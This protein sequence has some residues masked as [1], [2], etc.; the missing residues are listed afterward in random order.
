M[1]QINAKAVASY[2]LLPELGPRIRRLFLSGFGMIAYLMA[3]LYNAVRL[4]PYNH[5]YLSPKNIG[6]YGI[7]HVIG[8]AANN[9]VI[10]KENWDQILIFTA[11]LTGLILLFTQILILIFVFIIQP[12]FAQS[13]FGTP[14]PS[15]GAVTDVAFLLLDR[16]FGVPD[17]FCTVGGA[18]TDVLSGGRW[19]FHVALHEM[20]RFY[21][22]GLLIVAVLIFVYYIVVVVGETATTG[23]PFGERFQN[24]WVPI[25]LVVALFLLVP[26]NYGLNTAQY[27]ALFAAKTGSGFATNGWIMFN[28]T[29]AASM[30]ARAN[31]TGESETLLA[32]PVEPSIESVVRSMALVHG[33]AYAH[34]RGHIAPETNGAYPAQAITSSTIEP[35]FVKNP[36]DWLGG[37]TVPQQVAGSYADGLTFYGNSDITIRFGRDVSGTDAEGR[38][39]GDIEPTCGEIRINITSAS[40]DMSVGGAPMVQQAYYD[41]VMSLWSGSALLRDLGHRVVEKNYKIDD[42]VN[43]GDTPFVCQIGCGHSELPSCYVINSE[44]NVLKCRS[45]NVAFDGSIITQVSVPNQSVINAAIQ[46]AWNLYNLNAIDIEMENELKDR[47]WGG[48]GIWY[49]KI[50]KINGEFIGAVQNIPRMSKYP[51]IME[52]VR[53]EKMKLDSDLNAIEMYNPETSDD[54]NLARTL[55]DAGEASGATAMAKAAGMYKLYDYLYRNMQD[56]GNEEK[57]IEGNAFIDAINFIFGTHGV[58]AMRGENAHIHPLAQLSAAGKGIVNSAV[59]NLTLSTGL[60]L[61]GPMLGL[62]KVTGLF[63][64]LFSTTAFIGLT[65]GV[66]LYYI[67]PIMPFVF[68]FFAVGGWVKGLFEAMV[69]V[70]LWALAHLRMDG[71]GLPGEAAANGYF[72][73]LEIFIRPIL[74]VFGLVASTVIFAAQVRILHFI[75]DLVI[76][77]AGGFETTSSLVTTAD[78]S[79]QRDVVDKLFFTVSYVVVVYMMAT[80]SFKL[81]DSIPDNISRWGGS[82]ISSF[83]DQDKNPTEGLTRYAATGGMIQ[84]QKVVQGIQQTSSGLGQAISTAAGPN[85]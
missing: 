59:Q 41:L 79:L 53:Q 57:S 75:W 37:S 38:Y 5:P 34:W 70:P 77:N 35:Y 71:E 49:N 15:G 32:Y 6:K 4:L 9:L 30:G 7:R 26:I 2:L 66:V 44:D 12:V 24:V 74:I 8:E 55:A 80:A 40:T 83:G 58:F 51:L 65:A 60:S 31:P 39:T 3:F 21:S 64:S 25:R 14:D 33:C 13:I 16:V 20:F 29:I 23:T 72:L 36:V 43:R 47:G 73:I 61:F 81:I 27:I 45:T 10:K 22:M 42:E 76:E 68:F 28:N 63:A 85:R 78:F 50:A 11:I 54:Q 69:G 56:G 67:L 1:S 18:C 82:G 48:A 62:E 84:G 52:R 17:F 19:P 46:S